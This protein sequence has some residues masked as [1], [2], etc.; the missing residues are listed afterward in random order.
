[1]EDTMTTNN[2]REARRV[3]DLTQKDLAKKIGLTTSA[4]SNYE[5]GVSQPSVDILKEI[6]RILDTSV[7]YLIG[8]Q[9]APPAEGVRKSGDTAAI[10][11]IVDKQ[12]DML[13]S[14]HDMMKS[15]QETI[16][17]LVEIVAK[18]SK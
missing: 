17:A 16:T 18:T 7:E 12:Q 1:M 5:T 3:K 8:T 2:I 6:A 14:Q 9:G 15:Q 4:I 10:L 13:R 11:Q